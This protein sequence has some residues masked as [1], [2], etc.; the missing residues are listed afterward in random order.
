MHTYIFWQ[1]SENEIIAKSRC[2]LI[3]NGNDI[4][5]SVISNIESNDNPD[6]SEFGEKSP[7][8]VLA[9]RVLI[10]CVCANINVCP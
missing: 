4:L 10:R 8:F 1:P 2:K 7:S 5:W 9:A 3:G 6:A